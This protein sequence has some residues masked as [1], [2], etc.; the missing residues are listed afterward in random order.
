MLLVWVHKPKKKRLEELL[1]LFSFGGEW[2]MWRYENFLPKKC[3]NM[4]W[5]CYEC[6]RMYMN[7]KC[8]KEYIEMPWDVV[9]ELLLF[10]CY[11]KFFLR[12]SYVGD[13]IKFY[14]VGDSTKFY[15]E[16]FVC[17]VTLSHLRCLFAL[18]E[19]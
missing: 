19:P 15:W 16:T 17:F 4:M 14:Y 12:S 5:M 13:S 18:V 10:T 9:C 8:E 3:E 7:T 6:C 1:R 11:V 2:L